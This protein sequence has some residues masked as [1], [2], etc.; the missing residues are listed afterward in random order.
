MKGYC[1][2]NGEDDYFNITLDINDNSILTGDGKGKH[3]VDKKFT[4]LE[5]EV[6]SITI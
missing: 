5:L 2:T 1:C 3:D 6:Y 4:C